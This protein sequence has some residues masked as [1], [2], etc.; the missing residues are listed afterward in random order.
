MK[1]RRYARVVVALVAVWLAATVATPLPPSPPPD[2]V[3]RLGAG[4][5]VPAPVLTLLETACFDCHSDETAWPWYARV[6]PASWLVARHVEMGR[7]QLNFS[8]WNAYNAIDRADML[9]AACEEVREGRMPVPSYRLLH[10]EARLSD[11]QVDVLCTWTHAEA[12]RL[13]N[14]VAP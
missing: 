7:G 6:F 12:Q 9:D 14:E 11:A 3:T 1:T 8:R 5:P 2:A 4:T 10:A 13:A